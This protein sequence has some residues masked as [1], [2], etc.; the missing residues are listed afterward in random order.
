[1][2]RGVNVEWL[3]PYSNV[4]TATTL[5]PPPT[6]TPPPVPTPTP[7]PTP[8][9]Q[10]ADGVDNDGDG[11]VDGADPQCASGTTEAPYDFTACNDSADNDGDGLPD[12]ADPGCSSLTDSDE[13]DPGLVC[14]NGLDDDSD[15][16]SDYPADP[17]CSSPTD[18]DETDPS[19]TLAPIATLLW[20]LE[21]LRRK[22]P[23]GRRL[24][25]GLS[26]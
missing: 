5:S 13:H 3:G 2:V 10:C 22:R 19:P 24:M 20:G 11:F 26:P 7:V 17:G 14:D 9:P 18:P 6:P 12:L 15:L 8:P 21:V 16:L 25:L 23:S 1:M 4:I